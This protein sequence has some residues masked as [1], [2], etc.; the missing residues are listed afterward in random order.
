ML[1]VPLYRIREVY[2]IMVPAVG[3]VALK[4]LQKTRI[5]MRL[6][7]CL[8]DNSVKPITFQKHPTAFVR[9]ISICLPVMIRILLK[10]TLFSIYNMVWVK[11]KQ[12]EAIKAILHVSWTI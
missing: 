8:T 12:V 10:N 2:I 6:K 1:T 4:F 7:M 9:Y 11:T 3:E 5:S